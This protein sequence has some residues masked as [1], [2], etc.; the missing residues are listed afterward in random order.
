M[1]RCLGDDLYTSIEEQA[2]RNNEER[3]RT[4]F[5]HI[6]KRDVDLLDI[7]VAEKFD[8]LSDRGGR[9]L[10]GLGI[11]FGI[12]I[13][14]I[15]EHRNARTLRQQFTQEAEPFSPSL[16]AQGV[17]TGNV[18]ARLIETLRRDRARP[19]RLLSGTRSES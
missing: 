2:L 8:L 6:G 9:S 11:V 5:S 10:Q 19:D 12:R 7:A 3:I 1:E 4:P 14:R 15:D 17:D 16:Q 18:A 13:V